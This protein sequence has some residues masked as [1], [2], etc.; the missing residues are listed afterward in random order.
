MHHSFVG[1]LSI[2]GLLSMTKIAIAADSVPVERTWTVDGL[3]REALV[4]VPANATSTNTPV[5]FV[6]HGHGGN[7]QAMAKAMDIQRLWPEALVVYMQ[8]VPS[9]GNLQDFE[10]LK[11]GWEN[12]P[13]DFGDR[14]FKFFDQVLATLK[15]EYKVEDKRVYATGHSHGG[16]FTYLLW[17][18][19]GDRL[20]AVAPCAAFYKPTGVP[21]LPRPVLHMGGV[22][23][24]TVKWEWQQEAI[25][26][27]R[28]LNGC[29]DEGAAWASTGT[30]T[31]VQ[32]ACSKGAPVVMLTHPG[33]HEMP[34]GAPALIVR[35]FK[36]H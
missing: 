34:A 3:V 24:N 21:S 32:Y 2:A 27:D 18:Q 13:G 33:G 8:G 30:L 12:K 22:H 23:D 31:G 35:F 1:L 19:R 20:A 4:Y 10:G 7:R 6:F 5:V 29:G 36:E 17:S 28:K 15:A 9:P 25:A 14:D 26:A 11:N 16:F